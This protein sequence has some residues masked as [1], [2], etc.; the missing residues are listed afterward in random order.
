MEATGLV[1]FGAHTVHHEIV[2]NLDDVTLRREI[3]DSISEVRRRCARPSR[4]FA[5]PNGRDVDFDERAARVLSELGCI[6]AVST[7]EGLNDASTPRFALRRISVG[8]AMGFTEFRSRVSGLDSQARR[9]VSER[10]RSR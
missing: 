6:A 9:F 10:A 2:R 7:I 3:A 5:Y 8:G 1:S 4:V